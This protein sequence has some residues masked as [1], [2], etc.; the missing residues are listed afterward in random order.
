V[1]LGIL[2]SGAA[3]VSDAM[4]FAAAQALAAQ[5]NDCELASGRIFP[6]QSRLREVAVAVAESVAEVAFAQGLARHDRPADLAAAIRATMYVP[7]YPP[8]TGG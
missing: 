1:G 5:V 6:S 3:S 4:F 8:L 2:V 7:D